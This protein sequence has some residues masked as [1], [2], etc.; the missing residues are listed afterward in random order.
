MT[1]ILKINPIQIG[2]SKVLKNLELRG[3]VQKS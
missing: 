1:V 3:G 2:L